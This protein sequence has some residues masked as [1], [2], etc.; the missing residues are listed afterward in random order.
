MATCR[1]ATSFIV[2]AGLVAAFSAALTL[3]AATGVEGASS[4]GVVL[5]NG[6]DAGPDVELLVRSHAGDMG[7][8]LLLLRSVEM[9]WPRKWPMVVVL[10]GEHEDDQ[11]AA[12]LPKWLRVVREPRPQ[13][14]DLWPMLLKLGSGGM[15]FTRGYYRGVYGHWLSDLATVAP[16]VSIIDS[17]AVL[18][19]SVHGKMLFVGARPLIRA[20]CRD[21]PLFR[22]AIDALALP[23]ICNFMADQ[24]FTVRREHFKELREFVARSRCRHEFRLKVGWLPQR[25]IRDGWLDAPDEAELGNAWQAC[26]SADFDDVWLWYIGAVRSV[27]M[28]QGESEGSPH[29]LPSLHVV[30][31]HFL[32]FYHRDEYAWSLNSLTRSHIR[33]LDVDL[34]QRV[35]PFD[36]C[37]SLSAAKH[38]WV[39]SDVDKYNE[40]PKE[41]ADIR[42]FYSDAEVYLQAS[43]ERRR[44]CTANCGKLQRSYVDLAVALMAQGECLE[45]HARGDHACRL[46]MSNQDVLVRIDPEQGTVSRWCSRTPWGN[47][48][49]EALMHEHID[50]VGRLTQ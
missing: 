27:A 12:I 17:D 31:G 35:G 24:L 25:S 16:Y 8:L 45:R 3:A 37:P 10:D 9:F 14:Y 48:T 7:L 23:Y 6:E 18:V 34:G 22:F 33:R 28:R 50:I 11:V 39:R 19:A 38:P 26:V 49:L 30:M 21:K 32:W 36:A 40:D 46:H 43:R 47:R 44:S 15:H 29:A 20:G 42:M 41:E 13:Q 5:A 4:R 2:G 1:L